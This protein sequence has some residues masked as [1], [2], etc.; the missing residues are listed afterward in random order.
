MRRSITLGLLS[1]VMLMA[2]WGWG[3]SGTL[4]QGS[5]DTLPRG[6]D[7]GLAGREAELQGQLDRLR[8]SVSGM[9]PN[10]PQLSK[11]LERIKQLENDLAAFVTVPNPFTELE[12]QG[13]KP[14]DIVERLNERELR[15]LVV[16]LAVDLKDLRQRVTELEQANPR[17]F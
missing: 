5:I 15:T 1:S 16:R 11:S 7:R 2:A 6:K 13:V 12:Q 10:H 4:P 8:E 17:R 9:G 3:Q 14:Q